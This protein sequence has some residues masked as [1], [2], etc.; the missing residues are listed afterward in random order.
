MSHS[1]N[2]K[3]PWRGSHLGIKSPCM[4]CDV[5]EPACH[6][7]C[8]KYA[9]YRQKLSAANDRRQEYQTQRYFRTDHNVQIKS[10]AR[11]RKNARRK[12]NE[13]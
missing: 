12:R 11:A 2:E 13:L 5:R 10:S 8:D 3:S 4:E 7:H 9:V 1:K 6:D